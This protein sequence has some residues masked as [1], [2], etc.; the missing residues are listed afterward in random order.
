MRTVTSLSLLVLSVLLPAIGGAQTLDLSRT[1]AEPPAAAR[2]HTWW[3]WMNGNITREGITADL[4]AMKNVGLGGV[5]VFNVSESIPDGPAPFMSPQWRELFVFAVKEADRLGLEVCIHN[6]AGW[7]SSGGPWVTPEHAMQMVVTS[8]RAIE[9]PGRIKDAFPQPETRHG[10]Y[11]DIAVLAFPTPRSDA[12]IK[13]IRVKAGY[14][15]RYDQ[16]PALDLFAADSVIPLDAVRDITSSLKD[17]TLEW[18]APAGS[19]TIVRF[20][21]TCTGAMNAPSPDA[22]RGLECDKLSREALDRFWDDGVMAAVIKDL[23]PLAGKTLNNALV[24]S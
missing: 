13:D 5:Q 4:E 11:H 3:H 9:G 6:C 2:P 10:F 23:G 15:Y 21:H 14:E 19:W 12:R 1:F 7:S 20:G 17:G 16:Q 18:Q 22:G 8:E 24:D